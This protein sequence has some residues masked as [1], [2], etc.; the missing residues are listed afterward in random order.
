MEKH[1]VNFQGETISFNL[2][3]KKV[4]NVNLRVRSD[5]TVTVSASHNVPFQFIESFVMKKAPWILHTLQRNKQVNKLRSTN[6]FISGEIIYYRGKPFTLQVREAEKEKVTVENGSIMLYL[7]PGST[8]S[9]IK[10][11]Y[12]NWLKGEAKAVFIEALETLYPRVKEYSIQKPD[13][14]VRIMKTRWG[15]CSWKKGRITI[16]ALLVHYP[17]E[18]LEYVILHE[19]AHFR[20]HQHDQKFYEF[21]SKLLPDW[22]ERKNMLKSEYCFAGSREV[23]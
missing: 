11:N 3:R 16:N 8:K 21:I 20:H 6:D 7:K 15:S 5:L 4:K 10:K 17:S 14:S 23:K 1:S 19:L 2:S 18:C 9:E 22:Q 13:L 12:F